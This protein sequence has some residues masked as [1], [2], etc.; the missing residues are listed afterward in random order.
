MRCFLEE[1][2]KGKF[3]GEKKIYR[4]KLLKYIGNGKKGV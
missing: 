4:K 2:R 1:K 3:G